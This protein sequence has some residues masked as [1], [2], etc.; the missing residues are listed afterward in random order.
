[1]MVEC[2]PSLRVS[3]YSVCDVLIFAAG[4]VTWQVWV[5][6]FTVNFSV[7]PLWLR[8]PFVAVASFG[9]TMY[10]SVSACSMYWFTDADGRAVH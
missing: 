5:P 7:C 10:W 2:V 3:S 9:F 6:V 1:M 8:V 4:L